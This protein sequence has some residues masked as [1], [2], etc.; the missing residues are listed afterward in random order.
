[1]IEHLKAEHKS[2]SAI[3]GLIPCSTCASSPSV[4]L[5]ILSALAGG[6]L[7]L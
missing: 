3:Y 2:T 5:L 7:W 1:V 4:R 6:R